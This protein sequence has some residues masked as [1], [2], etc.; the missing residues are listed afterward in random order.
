M[1]CPH[2]GSVLP[3]GW[4]TNGDCRN[5]CSKL[6]SILIDEAV[7]QLSMDRTGPGKQAAMDSIIYPLY[8]VEIRDDGY[9]AWVL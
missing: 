8:T 4:H 7:R 6:P 1:F 3:P 5:C 9:I 2:C